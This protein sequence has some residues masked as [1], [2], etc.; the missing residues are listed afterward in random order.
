MTRSWCTSIA[1]P[2]LLLTASI[3]AAQDFC[4]DLDQLVKL[5]PSR[6]ESIRD[7]ATSGPLMTS[8]TR[9]LPGA[10]W[11]WYE[12]LGEAYWCSWDVSTDQMLPRLNDL[13]TEVGRCYRVQATRDASLSF[14]VVDLPNSVPI[15]VNGVGEMVFLSIGGRSR[16]RDPEARAPSGRPTGQVDVASPGDSASSRR[17]RLGS[18]ELP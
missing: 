10:S 2:I 4:A 11:C 7:K 18:I 5:V 13:A 15:Y 17:G 16:E 9:R 8:V 1:V 6:F 12:N 3:A 14:A